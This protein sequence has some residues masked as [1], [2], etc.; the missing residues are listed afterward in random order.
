MWEKCSM[1]NIRWLALGLALLAGFHVR[2]GEYNEK[3]NIGD[4]APAWEALPGADGKSHSL[5]ELKDKDVV[6][7]A[8]TCLSCP[9][10]V[11]YEDRIEALSKKFGGSEGKVGVVA[12]CV[13]KV[14]ADRL[15]KITDKAKQKGFSFQYL[16]DESQKI[17]GDYGAI[18]TPEFYVLNKDRKIVYMGAMDDAT[19]VANVKKHFV[20]DAIEAALSDSKPLVKET[21]ARGCRVRYVRERK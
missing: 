18:F 3:L 4:A 21:L 9:T 2:A 12:V 16:H 14:A 17:A 1:R 5:A 13:N 6:V 7:L 11:D 8:F 20:E 10:A 15:D 19:D